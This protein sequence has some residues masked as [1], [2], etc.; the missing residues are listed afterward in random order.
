MNQPTDDNPF[1]ERPDEHEE[2][3]DELYC[4]MPGNG[5]RQCGPDCVAFDTGCEEDGRKTT[6]LVL[7]IFRVIGVGAQV[8]ASGALDRQKAAKA[9]AITQKVQE[10]PDPPEVK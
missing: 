1:I 7:N 6:C 4:W 9:A 10:I 2:L 5:E 3:G 8:M